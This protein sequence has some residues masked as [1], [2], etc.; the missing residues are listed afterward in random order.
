MCVNLTRGRGGAGRAGGFLPALI[1]SDVH[2]SEQIPRSSSEETLD[3]SISRPESK[4]PAL[5]VAS[6]TRLQKNKNKQPPCPPPR[7]PPANQ[8]NPPPKTKMHS[9][10]I[11]SWPQFVTNRNPEAMNT[12]HLPHW[13][14]ATSISLSGDHKHD[15]TY[16]VTLHIEPEFPLLSHHP[17]HKCIRCSPKTIQVLAPHNF[18]WK[19]IPKLHSFASLK[20]DSHS[21]SKNVSI[22]TSVQLLDLWWYCFILCNKTTHSFIEML[23]NHLQVYRTLKKRQYSIPAPPKL[24][25]KILL[26]SAWIGHGVQTSPVMQRLECG[27]PWTKC[28]LL[29]SRWQT[30]R[31]QKLRTLK[32]TFSLIA[33][34]YFSIWSKKCIVPKLGSI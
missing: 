1:L 27:N 7:T 9:Y 15:S 3:R 26:W 34:S 21:Y 18:A 5:A 31:K 13:N 32:F 29:P 22:A 4:N 17:F 20:F 24:I 2:N 10:Q 19:S 14:R 12:R 28:F 6:S 11:P 23:P 30:H 25:L 33:R 16:H 8:S